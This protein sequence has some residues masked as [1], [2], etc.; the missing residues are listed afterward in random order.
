[1]STAK[2]QLPGKSSWETI[3]FPCLFPWSQLSLKKG[4][5]FPFGLNLNIPYFYFNVPYPAKI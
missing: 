1:M 5:E 2:I 3:Y 4:Q